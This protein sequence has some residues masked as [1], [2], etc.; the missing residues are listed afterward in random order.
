MS[1]SDGITFHGLDIEQCYVFNLGFYLGV[2]T[3]DMFRPMGDRLKESLY[4]NAFIYIP[5]YKDKPPYWWR[6]DGTP[7]SSGD[8]PKEY[9][10]MAALLG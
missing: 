10:A 4:Q 8:V 7:R 9:I 5:R 6:A 1:N 2:M 3:I